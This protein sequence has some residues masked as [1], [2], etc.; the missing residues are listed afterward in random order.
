MTTNPKPPV[1]R[2]LLAWELGAGMG[3]VSK[4][5]EVARQLKSGE[6]EIV[7]S[8]RNLQALHEEVREVV[9]QVVPGTFLHPLVPSKQFRTGSYADILGRYGFSRVDVLGSILGAWDGLIH[10]VKPSVIIGDFAPFLTLAAYRELP[11]ISIGSS[12]CNPPPGLDRFPGLTDGPGCG[13]TEAQLLANVREVQRRRH[14]PE[15]RS[16]PEAVGGDAQVVM[17]LPEFDLYGEFRDSPADGPTGGV[18]APLPPPR[19]GRKLFVYLNFGIPTTRALLAALC[20][21]GLPVFGHVRDCPPSVLRE[22]R[23]RGV[24]LSEAPLPMDRALGEASGVIHHGG[25]N[26]LHQAAAAGRPQLLLPRHLEHGINSQMACQAG[27]AA[28]L[29]PDAD[30]GMMLEAVRGFVGDDSLAVKARRFADSIETRAPFRAL[31]QVVDLADQFAS[32]ARPEGRAR[33]T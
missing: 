3:H 19:D 23:E 5:L 24:R 9:D 26:T 1:K 2:A 13:V 18:T 27:I 10:Y 15:P 21:A 29:P 8:G 14:R 25:V 31:D 28:M 11:V 30:E 20:R 12:F 6:W 17:T 4:L 32:G 22:V 33:V 16:L 7:Y